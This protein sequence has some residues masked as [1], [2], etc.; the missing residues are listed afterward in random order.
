MKAQSRDFFGGCNSPH[1]RRQ[2]AAFLDTA[3]TANERCCIFN[4]AVGVLFPTGAD[5]GNKRETQWPAAKRTFVVTYA[6]RPM[7]PSVPNDHFLVPFLWR[8]A[9]A[10][11][12]A[13]F[14]AL[15]R[16]FV[17][18]VASHRCV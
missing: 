5:P 17:V 9:P 11:A 12:P 18:E 13:Q 3:F 1:V 4:P 7:V 16:H 6:R 14:S 10:F 2:A 15:P 8:R